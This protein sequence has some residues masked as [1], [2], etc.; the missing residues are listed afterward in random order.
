MKTKKDRRNL[1]QRRMDACRTL[2]QIRVDLVDLDRIK[3]EAKCPEDVDYYDKHGASL[4]VQLIRAAAI[5]LEKHPEAK[6]PTQEQEGIYYL[7]L[8]I[9]AS[10]RTIDKLGYC[11]SVLFAD[12][13]LNEEEKFQG[14]ALACDEMEREKDRLAD[15]QDVL[16]RVETIHTVRVSIVLISRPILM[17][18]YICRMWST[19]SG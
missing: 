15:T 9:A 6:R 11:R 13:L 18:F 14:Y 8:I 5:F 16:L 2:Q 7:I 17:L 4:R 12:I 10:K 19:W 3:E 1:L